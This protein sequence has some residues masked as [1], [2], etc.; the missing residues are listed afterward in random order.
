MWA[1]VCSIGHGGVVAQNRSLSH[2]TAA[3]FSC[4]FRGECPARTRAPRRL[5]QFPLCVCHPERSEGSASRLS[6]GGW[7]GTCPD[8]VGSPDITARPA[9]PLSFRTEQADFFP[10]VAPA[11]GRPAQRE[12][13]LRFLPPARLL[14]FCHPDRSGRSFPTLANAN[15]GRGVEGSA[16]LFS[17]GGRGFSPDITPRPTTP[18]S[19]R[20]E[21]AD[22]FPPV[23]PATGRPAQREISLR[24]LSA[25]CLSLNASRHSTQA[26]PTPR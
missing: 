16:F 14:P 13:S 12:I 5:I 26:P 19:F 3:P 23:A 15:A 20:T 10:P 2:R 8:R 21:Q 1:V 24:S 7:G 25:P 11:T 18:P 4:V 17:L 22:F 6:L 9:A